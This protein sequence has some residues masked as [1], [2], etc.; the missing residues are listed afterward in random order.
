MSTRSSWPWK[1]RANS[2]G[3]SSRA[4]QARPVGDRAQLAEHARVGEADAELRVESGVGER[5]V[6]GALQRVPQRRVGAADR[7]RVV[8][9]DLDLGALEQLV[10]E[11]CP[12]M[13]CDLVGVL[14][15]HRADVDV[16]I[17]DV[18]DD[19]RLRLSRRGDD[20]RRERRMRAGVEEAL[21]RRGSARPASR[22][23]ERGRRRA[24]PRS[25]RRR[26]RAT[27]PAPRHSSW[28][29]G[30][31]R[32]SARRDTILAARDQ[33]VVRTV[34]HRT[35]TRRAAYPHPAPRHTFLA[36]GEVDA[37]VALGAV[38]E[39]AALGEQVVAADRV[40]VFGRRPSARRARCPPPRRRRRSTPG[41]LSGRK[42]RRT[43]V[44]NTTAIDAVRLSMSTAPRPHTSP[45]I[46]SPPN[47]SCR[48]PSRLTGTTSV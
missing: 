20:V 36:D 8:H 28:K 45:S 42:P 22:L 26:A 19:V 12:Q 23:V 32:Y 5:N 4:E 33:R 41:R 10:T 11:R 16:D 21:R 3:S 27:Q 43:S 39:T 31:G 38:V 44:R 13:S 17:D 24:A 7:R 35:V 18:G 1:R 9:Q 48:Q 47:G 34:R 6:D 46:S 2:P 29:R 14:T 30:A 25:C 15:W 40:G 37:A